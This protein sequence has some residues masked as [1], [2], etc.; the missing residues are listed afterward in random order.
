M[1]LNLQDGKGTM[2]DTKRTVGN[3]I[4]QEV[5]ELAKRGERGKGL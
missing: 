1:C 4:G 2:W 5:S 3:K